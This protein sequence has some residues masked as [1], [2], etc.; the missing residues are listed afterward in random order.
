MGR[1]IQKG[2]YGYLK[3][4]R[5]IEIRRTVLFFGIS[6]ALFFTGLFFTGTNKNLLTI[7]AVLGMLPASKSAV[8]M[9]M[10]LRFPSGSVE[11]YE[12]TKIHAKSLPAI[13]DFVIT[14]REKSFPLSSMVYKDRMLYGFC[15]R[16]GENKKE[17]ES[18]L[19]EML[20]SNHYKS[21]NVKIF[22]DFP[23]YLKRLDSL[24]S[25]E[26]GQKKEEDSNTKEGKNVLALL[27]SL[28]I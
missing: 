27:L 7:V 22:D 24:K 5:K 2:Q 19:K 8:S 11:L 18:Y 25:Q 6:F 23:K 28:S 17:L 9:I 26:K 14:S 4:Q 3:S 12:E 10:F 15:E 16:K 20:D 1:K 21:V 13:Y